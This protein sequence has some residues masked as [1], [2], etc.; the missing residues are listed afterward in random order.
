MRG[1]IAQAYPKKKSLNLEGFILINAVYNRNLEELEVVRVS[2]KYLKIDD[3]ET[4]IKE[5]K[6][7]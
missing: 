6:K 4:V 3:V 5:V 1:L 2:L 7:F